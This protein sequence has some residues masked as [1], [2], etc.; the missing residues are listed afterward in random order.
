MGGRKENEEWRW[1]HEFEV[2]LWKKSRK[3]PR[4]CAALCGKG[5]QEWDTKLGEV[6]ET[7]MA[8]HR[9]DKVKWENLL[10]N[11]VWSLASC[12]S[13][14]KKKRK[15]KRE[16]N[17]HRCSHRHELEPVKPIWVKVCA[18]CP[19]ETFGHSRSRS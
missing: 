13:R 4:N 9:S 5:G 15:R 12:M 6:L 17:K 7:W 11:Y 14:K 19:G 2:R 16:N 18:P 1:L 10:L 8:Y 3:G